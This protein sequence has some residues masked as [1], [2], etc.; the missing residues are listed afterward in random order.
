MRH[1]D[2]RKYYL[3]HKVIKSFYEKKH[4]DNF[5]EVK[6]LVRNIVVDNKR[7]RVISFYSHKVAFHKYREHDEMHKRGTKFYR[8][9]KRKY[10]DCTPHHDLKGYAIVPTAIHSAFRH[11]GTVALKNKEPP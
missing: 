3:G 4:I 8:T 1:R 2:R 5:G 6:V 10:P 11:T 7:K 9:L